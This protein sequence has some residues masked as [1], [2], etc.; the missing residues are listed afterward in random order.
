VSNEVAVAAI[1]GGATLGGVALTLMA[2]ALRERRREARR[3][4]E[5]NEKAEA[6]RLIASRHVL[7]ELVGI[8]IAAQIVRNDP[9]SWNDPA[10]KAALSPRVAWTRY[11]DQLNFDDETIWSEVRLAYLGADLILADGDLANPWADDVRRG[12]R[13]IQR[14]LGVGPGADADDD[15][16]GDS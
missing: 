3:K 5:A 9:G 16:P 13:A 4:A 15:V 14:A 6:D 8:D 1:T 2:D 10:V 12:L 11:S 7:G